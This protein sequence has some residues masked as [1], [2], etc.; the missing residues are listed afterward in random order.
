M[1][2]QKRKTS[3]TGSGLIA[4]LSMR[5]WAEA[6]MTEKGFK[7]IAVLSMRF[8]AKI[9]RKLNEYFNNKLPFSL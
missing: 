2:F 4:V 6:I 5:F 7:P 9:R 1:R 3:G 8:S